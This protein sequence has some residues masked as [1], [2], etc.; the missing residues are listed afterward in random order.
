MNLATRL[1]SFFRSVRRNPFFVGAFT[2]MCVAIILFAGSFHLASAQTPPAAPAAT[3]PVATPPSSGVVS[4]PSTSDF[5]NVMNG[6]SSLT[7]GG[8]STTGSGPGTCLLSVVGFILTLIFSIISYFLSKLLIVLTAVLMTFARYNKFNNAP[9]V[10]IGWVIVRDIANMFFIVVLLISAFM[11]IIG[12]AEDFGFHYSKVIPKLLVAAVLVNFSKTIILLLIDFSQVVTLTFIS[13]FEGT[14]AGNVIQGFGLT[15][16]VRFQTT[17]S[18]ADYA[19]SLMNVC[20]AYMLSIFLLTT[21]IATLLL[22][23]GYFIFRIIALWM[24]IIFSPLAF[25]VGS[26]PGKAAE[27]AK[28]AMGGDF[29]NKFTPLLTGG[30]LIAFFLWL[31]FATIQQ[32]AATGIANANIGFD[33]PENTPIFITQIGTASQLTSY[34]VAVVMMMMGF[35]VATSTAD[36]VQGLGA[37]KGF[38][39]KKRDEA[40]K[41][42]S[43]APVT[44]TGGALRGVGRGI[45]AGANAVD[46]RYGVTSQ[47]AA[48]M[49]RGGNV[50]GANL[51][52]G[53][54][55][56]GSLGGAAGN[57][58][59]MVPVVGGTLAAGAAGSLAGRR[60][61]LMNENKKQIEERIKRI[62]NLP[63]E[64]RVAAIREMANG[65]LA[66]F[67]GPDLIEKQHELMG[68]E[69]NRKAALNTIKTEEKERLETE[70]TNDMYKAA[71]AANPNANL[72]D[73]KLSDERKAEIGR[74]AESLATRRL[75]E[76]D[77]A[78]IAQLR[79]FAADANDGGRGDVLKKEAEK[80]MLFDMPSDYDA[81]VRKFMGNPAD[82]KDLDP[83]VMKSGMF[84]LSLMRESGA[85]D[86]DAK[87]VDKHR[88]EQMKETYKDQKELLGTLELVQ[89]QIEGGGLSRAD[90]E[91][92]TRQKDAYGAQRM[93]ATTG[94]GQAIYSK[95]ES[96][97]LSTLNSAASRTVGTLST[98]DRAAID[99]A[100]QA[101]LPVK[102]I[103]GLIDSKNSSGASDGVTLKRL[104]E[105]A[106]ETAKN[107]DLT[108]AQA[109]EKTA[110]LVEMA[111]TANASGN[112]FARIIT[113]AMQSPEAS[114]RLFMGY[115]QRTGDEK[116]QIFKILESA[117]NLENTDV[118]VHE[119]LQHVKKN[120]FPES[121]ITTTVP[122]VSEM[123]ATG[124]FLRDEEG[125]ITTE[126]EMQKVI[127]EKE[128]TIEI[129]A[130]PAAVRNVLHG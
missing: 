24:I 38:V 40:F 31:T 89:K 95:A 25:L 125:N 73:M 104:A 122:E 60:A 28:G 29:W 17:T 81:Q 78:R 112:E 18:G 91:S 86:A 77:S 5:Q 115:N 84:A 35:Q 27:Q 74:Q 34:I 30:P 59:R 117:A 71:R 68:K 21:A 111:K 45:R 41:V 123:K 16:M 64:A 48:G 22:Y 100:I 19:V 113:A 85:T 54:R 42:L 23:V 7:C 93:Y 130:A 119:V 47:F 61:G 80:R 129:P 97:A 76:E 65:P 116:K 6:A 46:R 82:L 53:Q 32:T 63:P 87:T 109:L 12:K 10:Q 88:I 9:P 106:D 69:E 2:L 8:D 94:D 52:A 39:T 79:A 83:S 92:S 36:K 103:I 114:N 33:F 75:N 56:L 14:I 58:M 96:N 99:Q 105:L 98:A 127:I 102:Q 15:Q 124:S 107:S 49:A 128:K 57:A 118:H 121:K 37:L 1:S 4:G 44:L 120:I 66:S 11:T 70:A 101:D 26:L 62:E 110:Q 108:S 3:T 67:A 72:S 43:R 20:L 55:A 51:T 50:P 13:A 126:P 90:I